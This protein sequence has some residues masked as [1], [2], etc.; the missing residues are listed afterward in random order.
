MVKNSDN[1]EYH[2]ANEKTLKSSFENYKVAF[3][4]GTSLVTN[5]LDYGS[6]PLILN[7][8]SHMDFKDLGNK[9]IVF[10]FNDLEK[11]IFFGQKVVNHKNFYKNWS[12]RCLKF[13]KKYYN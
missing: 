13:L 11:L 2:F 9:K 5:A 1:I 6:I 7:C 12:K 3:V 4:Y 8:K 10:V